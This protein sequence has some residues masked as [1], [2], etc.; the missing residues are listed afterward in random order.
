MLPPVIS[1]W[2]GSKIGSQSTYPGR[3]CIIH[4]FALLCVWSANDIHGIDYPLAWCGLVDGLSIVQSH[5]N[6]PL[7]VW[8]GDGAEVS[9]SISQYIVIIAQCTGVYYPMCSRY[10]SMHCSCCSIDCS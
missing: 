8:N 10:C 1:R 3:Y 6:P 2:N 5:F 4:N 9:V 7:V